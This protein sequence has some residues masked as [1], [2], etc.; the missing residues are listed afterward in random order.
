MLKIM[1]FE[2]LNSDFDC[3]LFLLFFFVLCCKNMTTVRK[4]FEYF[5]FFIT[6]IHDRLSF[7]KAVNPVCKWFSDFPLSI[8]RKLLSVM[9]Y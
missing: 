3:A 2:W 5:D 6:E 9:L 7:M 8:V 4:F 1:N